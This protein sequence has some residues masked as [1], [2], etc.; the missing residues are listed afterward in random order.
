MNRLFSFLVLACSYI[1]CGAQA[2]TLTIDNQTPGWLSSKINFGDQQTVENLTVTGYLNP[3]DLAFIGTLIKSHSLHGKIDLTNTQIVDA[4]GVLTNKIADIDCFNVGNYYGDEISHLLMS[5]F[6]TKAVSRSLSLLKIDSLTIGSYNMPIMSQEYFGLTNNTNGDNHVPVKTLIFREGVTEICKNFYNLD[7][8]RY[9][10]NNLKQIVMPSTLKII[11]E[12][13]FNGNDSLKTISIPNTVTTIGT[14]A[15]VGTSFMPDTLWLPDSL[16]LY[17]LSSFDLPKEQVVIVPKH[18]QRL[19]FGYRFQDGWGYDK[20]I[21]YIESSNK[22]T[23]YMTSHDMPKA[24]CGYEG[25]LSGSTFYVRKDLVDTY[26]QTPPFDR[27]TILAAIESITISSKSIDL[28][29]GENAQLSFELL[30]ENAIDKSVSWHSSDDSIVRIDKFGKITAVSAGT[31]KVYVTS[32]YDN[33]LSDYCDITVTQPVTGV[34]LNETSIDLPEDGNFKLDATVI[35]D[36]ATNKNVAWDSS[37]ESVAMVTA[38]GM[39]YGIKAGKATI[40]VTTEDGAFSALCKVNV[41]SR[42]V[43]VAE[44]I[45]DS[46]NIEG[47]ETEEY[48]IKANVLPEDASN[49]ILLW[50]SSDETVASVDN[51]GLIRLLKKGTSIIT[52]S[53]TDESGVFAECIVLVSQQAGI[54]EVIVDKN[55]YVKIYNLSGVLVFEGNYSDA[56][57]DSGYYIVLCGGKSHSVI[58]E[59]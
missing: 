52:V 22:I 12:A 25:C 6:I 2:T 48:L 59:K 38:D 34:V 54:D 50:R 8:S 51:T 28:K 35:P 29:A 27:A 9:K 32:N 33:A 53:A 55:T 23:F 13:A 5:K 15:F 4:N 30:P 17:D 3:T 10:E 43:P 45:L 14:E 40:M 41:N 58:V 44:I 37:D 39:V 46:T 7:H 20:H 16:E 31:A 56:N 18:I 42:F 19:K 57:L 26:K 49:K 36:N 21:D 11:G 47:K 1:L 24:T